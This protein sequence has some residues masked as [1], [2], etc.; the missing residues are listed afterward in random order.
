MNKSLGFGA[1]LS[2]RQNLAN[3]NVPAE[4]RDE[5]K[6]E[7]AAGRGKIVGP[8]QYIPT[9]QPEYSGLINMAKFRG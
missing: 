8:Q 2:P 7:Q 6:N 9:S 1:A 4:Y 5:S 3:S